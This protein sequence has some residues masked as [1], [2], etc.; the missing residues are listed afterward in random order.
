[1]PEPV[2][3]AIFHATSEIERL[4]RLVADLLIVA[5]RTGGPKRRTSIGALVDA[6]REM[7]AP[8]SQ[9]RGVPVE[10]AGD[11]TVE[12]DGD[13]MARAIDNLLKNAVEA[14]KKGDR[15]DV[16]IAG[17][18]AD[19]V[20]RVKDH[21]KGVPNGREAELFE[22]FFT[23]KP[24]GSGLGLALSRAIARAHGGD[25]VYLREK[26]T[27]LFELT[28]PVGARPLE[29]SSPQASGRAGNAGEVRA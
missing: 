23:T 25:L 11:A 13:S 9:E 18:G 7:L 21:G 27:T 20:V 22:P 4:D 17:R 5:G 24:E 19:V 16:E 1:L 15:V 3:K 14:S 10:V 2:E 8:W 28:L 12:V 6:R 26:E 29:G